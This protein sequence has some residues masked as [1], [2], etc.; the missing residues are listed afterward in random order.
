MSKWLFIF[1]Y[2]YTFATCIC[3]VNST[4]VLQLFVNGTNGRGHLAGLVRCVQCKLRVVSLS[5]TLGIETS[6]ETTRNLKKMGG[7]INR[8]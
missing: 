3:S 8:K 4:L 1:P 5:H 2:F 6:R 7:G